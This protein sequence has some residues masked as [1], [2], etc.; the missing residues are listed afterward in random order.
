MLH[1]CYFTVAFPGSG[2]VGGT[3]PAKI[4]VHACKRREIVSTTTN[5]RRRAVQ[6]LWFLLAVLMLVSFMPHSVSAASAKKITMMR[7]E[8]RQ[9]KKRGA[10]WTSRNPMVAS[11]SPTGLVSARNGGKAV[12]VARKGKKQYRFKITVEAPTFNQT[13]IQVNLNQTAVLRVLGTSQKFRIQS[14]DP[15]VVSVRKVKKKKN[16]FRITA[17]KDGV[18]TVSA[19]YKNVV[20]NCT[21]TAGKGNPP[22]VKPEPQP[23]ATTFTLDFNGSPVQTLTYNKSDVGRYVSSVSRYGQSAPLYISTGGGDGLESIFAQTNNG[24]VN[25]AGAQLSPEACA[26]TIAK[27]CLWAR[28]VCDSEY[29]GYDDGQGTGR[30]RYTFGIAKDDSPGTGD[31]CCYSL[32]ECAYYFAGVNLLGECL[33][34]PA[35]AVYPPFSNMLFTSRGV[36]FWGDTA[37]VTT[38]PSGAKNYYPKAGFVDVTQQRNQEGADKFVYQAGDIVVSSSHQHEQLVI[39]SGTAKTCEVAE[40]CG[41]GAGKRKGGDQSGGELCVYDHLYQPNS[42]KAVYRFTGKGVVLNTVGLYG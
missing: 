16:R 9:L 36:S 12:I 34:N 13:A 23:Q 10:V 31:Y 3:D 18:A 19:V 5:L 27:A 22:P 4:F 30:A 28:A 6:A 14:S 37:P 29:H 24:N 42:V 7:G 21:V 39:K 33:G 11:V 20:V 17:L 35:A 2:S 15:S 38:A 26:G 41:P 8:V 25:V 1:N 40:A 32:A